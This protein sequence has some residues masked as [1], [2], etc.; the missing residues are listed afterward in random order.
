M[1]RSVLFFWLFSLVVLHA[2]ETSDFKAGTEAYINGDFKTAV[3]HW[4]LVSPKSDVV[5]YNLGNAYYRMGKAGEAVWHYRKALQMNPGDSDIL[6]NLQFAGGEFPRGMATIRFAGKLSPD[7]WGSHALVSLFVVSLCLFFIY[8]RIVPA[9]SN[10]VYLLSAFL[11]LFYSVFSIIMAQTHAAWLTGKDAVVIESTEV[12]SEPL[13]G[14]LA[15][16]SVD[17]GL[18]MEVISERE[19]FLRVRFSGD[20]EGW[21][22]AAKVRS[23]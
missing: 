21:V 20:R 12:R 4:E 15:L 2:G 9:I 1:K 19:G 6:H 7:A 14:S 23:L 11:A 5:Y 13:P 8:L 18:S 16:F 3:L 22:E 10:K 17:P